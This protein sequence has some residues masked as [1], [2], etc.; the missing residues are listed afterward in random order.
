VSTGI[1]A[2]KG[3]TKLDGVVKITMPSGSGNTGTLS[4]SDSRFDV[5]LADSISLVNP[6]ITLKPLYPIKLTFQVT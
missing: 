5:Y 6:K 2:M 4:V 3:T 1:G